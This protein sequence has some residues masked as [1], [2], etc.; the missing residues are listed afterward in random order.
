MDLSAIADVQIVASGAPLALPGFGKPLILGPYGKAWT[1]RARSYDSIE[2]VEADFAEGTPEHRLALALFSQD[3]VPTSI[4]IGRGTRIPT[5]VFEV[6]IASAVSGV[7]YAFKF[8]G[9]EVKFTSADAVAANILAGLKTALDALAIAGLVTVVG[10]GKLTITGAAGACHTFGSLDVS[11]VTVAEK[12]ADPGAGL[13]LSEIALAYPDFYEV[14]SAFSGEA[15]GAA[16]ATWTEANSRV[17]R[18]VLADSS[19]I[20]DAD[21]VATDLAHDLKAA[22]R[23]R[24]AT[25]YHPDTSEALAA[26]AAGR[27]LPEDPGSETQAMKTLRGVTAPALSATHVENLKAKNCGFYAT[28][29]GRGVVLDGKVASGEWIDV[30]RGLDALKVEMQAGIVDLLTDPTVKKVAYT[31]AGLSMVAG[32]VRAALVK[33][34]K[35]GFLV[36]GSSVVNVPKASEIPSADKAARRASGITFAANIAGAIHFVSTRGTVTY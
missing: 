26:A 32:K 29:A 13:D 35:R 8:D 20:L 24:T 7:D 30:I 11:K 15:F 9:S 6:A 10:G 19:V 23:K 28:V 1:E 5:Q 34:E 22:S 3:L 17:A 2:A 31:D 18:V 36:P 12:T 16:L 27:F 33:Y 14:H 4:A 21:S 25:Y